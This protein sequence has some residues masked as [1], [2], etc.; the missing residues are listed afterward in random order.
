LAIVLK[1]VGACCVSAATRRTVAILWHSG[2][3]SWI[4]KKKAHW[5]SAIKGICVDPVARTARS[6]TGRLVGRGSA[7][8]PAERWLGIRHILRRR[9]GYETSDYAQLPWPARQQQHAR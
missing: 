4:R 9:R 2:Q 3:A 5:P 7:Q 8:Q 1:V 6:G